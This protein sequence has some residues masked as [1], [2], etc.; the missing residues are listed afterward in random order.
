[1]ICSYGWH[2]K[3]FSEKWRA[4]LNEPSCISAIVFF[5]EELPSTFQEHLAVS[6]EII[7]SFIIPLQVM[8]THRSHLIVGGLVGCFFNGWWVSLS[9]SLY[10]KLFPTIFDILYE[11]CCWYLCITDFPDVIP[12]WLNSQC[13]KLLAFEH[14]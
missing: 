6:L 7:K 14:A 8:S 4:V 10:G 5:G 2:S 3:I 1:M 13:T 9:Q 12:L 11:T